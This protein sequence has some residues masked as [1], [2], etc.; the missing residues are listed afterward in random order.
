MVVEGSVDDLLKIVGEDACKGC[1]LYFYKHKDLMEN[2]SYVPVYKLIRYLFVRYK[3]PNFPICS[4]KQKFEKTIDA[5]LKNYEPSYESVYQPIV[6]SL[7][8]IVGHHIKESRFFDPL[9]GIL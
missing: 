5:L 1:L 9:D 4:L 7:A 8:L 6:D 2:E 3:L